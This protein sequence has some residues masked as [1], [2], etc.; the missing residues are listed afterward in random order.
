MEA[1]AGLA[2]QLE[3]SPLGAWVRGSAIGY[4]LANLLHLLGLVLLLGGIGLMDLRLA[5]AFR[6]L[7]AAALARVLIPGA[8]VGLSLL[9]VSGTM[10][11]AADA[12]PLLRSAVFRWKL[13][14]VGAA[15]LNVAAFHLLWGGRFEDW[16]RRA[17]L[18]ARLMAAGSL[19]LW[20][21]AASLGRLIAY[22]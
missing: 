12:Q 13:L 1:I 20:L 21:S 7:P 3:G 17:R 18:P 19:A 10:M 6:A 4:P 9:A 15:L 22:A 8:V 14:V 16:D 5:G 11:F 2:A